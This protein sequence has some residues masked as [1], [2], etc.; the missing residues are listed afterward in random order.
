MNIVHVA[1]KLSGGAGIA[2]F[3]LHSA[4]IRQGIN[5]R[6][7]IGQAAS[8]TGSLPGIVSFSKKKTLINRVLTV[9]QR[10][11]NRLVHVSDLGKYELFSKP[12][13]LN[14]ISRSEALKA[15]DI[16]HLHWIPNIDV[17]QIVHRYPNK[18]FVWT[19]QDM[20]PFTGG[21]HYSFGCAGFEKR[22]YPCPQM[23]DGFVSRRLP[24][25]ALSKKTSSLQNLNPQN[26]AV[27]APSQWLAN[28]AA[29]SSVLGRYRSVKILNPFPY[30]ENLISKQ[31]ARESLGWSQQAI[32]FL[33]V[34]DSLSNERKG[35]R[36]LA[37]A[38]MTMPESTQLSIC[39][40]GASSV[41]YNFGG[42]KLLKFGF[43][44]DEV[45]IQR[46]ISAC[47][48]LI[49]PSLEDNSPNVIAEA[50]LKGVPVC[51]TPVGGIAEMID[52]DNGILFSSISSK[53][54]ALGIHRMISLLKADYF[55]REKIFKLAVELYN[56][57]VVADKYRQ[58]YQSILG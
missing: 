57:D 1:S 52:A 3:R 38:L 47:D 42:C 12:F 54:I 43:V 29:Q 36:R 19:L 49:V 28:L 30:S 4:L 33:V 31:Q 48:A 46:A 6:F 11:I 58:L 25:Y 21:C 40:L 27:V 15:A 20:N 56:Q 44:S 24:Q 7:L 17:G 8:P 14:D 35:L 2:A 10:S 22:C 53:D 51:A 23:S 9:T 55:S 37:E 45:I 41:E 50:H 34:A 5:S 39:L 16:I 18:K 32:V 26:V 13:P